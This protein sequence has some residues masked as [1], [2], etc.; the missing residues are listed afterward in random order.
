[1]GIRPYLCNKCE[2]APVSEELIVC[3]MGKV[4]SLMVCVIIKTVSEKI[5]PEDGIRSQSFL[6][7]RNNVRMI[8]LFTVK[9]HA[10]MHGIPFA[11]LFFRPLTVSRL[12]GAQHE[13]FEMHNRLP[14][15]RRYR[16]LYSFILFCQ[17]LNLI[18]ESLP[19]ID[20]FA[21]MY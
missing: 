1:M 5:S 19:G 16:K 10:N 8:F 2:E 9:L 6:V 21:A 18:I 20:F 7:A 4:I 12:S 11:R 3:L 14:N 15:N 13:K 17:A